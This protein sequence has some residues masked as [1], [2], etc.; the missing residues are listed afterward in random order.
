MATNTAL[1]LIGRDQAGVIASQLCEANRLQTAGFE[2]FIATLRGELE[3]V[4]SERREL[5]GKVHVLE[6]KLEGS[7]RAHE[8]MQATLQ[9]VE[10]EKRQLQTALQ[11][12]TTGHHRVRAEL[13]I[14]LREKEQAQTSLA[15]QQTQLATALRQIASKDRLGAKVEERR[16]LEVELKKVQDELD[17]KQGGI[18]DTIA[19]ACG[20]V[21]SLVT[22]WVIGLI[23][24]LGGR[25]LVSHLTLD[26]VNCPCTTPLFARQASIQGQLRLVNE[27]IE[28]L[29]RV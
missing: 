5:A 27:E 25:K 1:S 8:V 9:R 16:S 21:L 11:D 29:R 17:A 15:E 28:R 19:L 12:Q 24:G 3:K 7:G 18:F 26:N 23:V 13:E 10:T 6:G 20:A 22:S 14:A 4:Q 2:G